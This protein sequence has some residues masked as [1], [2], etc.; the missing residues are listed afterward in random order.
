[1]TTPLVTVH[2]WRVPAR[3]LPRALWRM[4]VDRWLLRRTAGV[5]FS[6]LLGT[7][8]RRAFGPLSADLTRWATLTVWDGADAA[9]GF[10]A[11]RTARGWRRIASA[12]CRLDLRPVASQGRWSGREPFPAP[13]GRPGPGPVA[14]ITRARLAPCRALTFWRAIP[15]VAAALPGSGGLRAAFGIGEAPVGWQGTFSVWRSN[16]DLVDFAYRHPQHTAAV[17]RTATVRWYAEDLFA[18][19]SVLAVEGDRAVLDWTEDQ[20]E[21]RA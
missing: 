12:E 20:E 2:V 21:R 10:D 5:R 19:F 3:A 1:M 7:G 14:A 15:P 4:A 11:T 17:A 13:A 16:A 9:A 8:S 18:R 6:K